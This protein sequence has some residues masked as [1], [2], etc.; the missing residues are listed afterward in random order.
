MSRHAKPSDDT[1]KRHTE[2]DQ[3]LPLIAAK[4]AEHI[5]SQ[6]EPRFSEAYVRGNAETFESFVLGQS[7]EPARTHFRVVD[8]EWFKQN[9]LQDRINEA[10]RACEPLVQQ[11]LETRYGITATIEISNGGSPEF[12]FDWYNCIAWRPVKKRSFWRFWQR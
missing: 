1:A 8:D 2:S 5:I 3:T 11:L 7:P 12:I 9:N 4:A 6:L 10:C